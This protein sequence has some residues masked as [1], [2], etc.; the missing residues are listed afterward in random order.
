MKTL[1][2]LCLLFLFAANSNAAEYEVETVAE[3]LSYPW[4]MAFLP[5]GDMLVTERSGQLR[6]ISNGELQADPITNLPEIHVGGQGGLLD[7]I[8]DPAF[9]VNHRLYLSFSIGNKSANALQVISARLDENRLENITILFT[10]SPT[11]D[12]PH[13]FGGR[14]ALMPD[15]TLLITV[16]EG[17]DYRERAQSLD[18]HFGKLIRLN[19]DGT[20]PK[21]NPFVERE[22]TLPEIWTYGHRTHRGYWYRPMV[23]SGYMST[24]RAAAMS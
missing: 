4:A 12:T 22:D 10:A 7:V 19:K 18:N 8:L 11:K 5:D 6:R 21:D 1:F 23:R 16:G 24:A 14:L 2:R 20:V 9:E 15:Q 3:G 17:F 13:H